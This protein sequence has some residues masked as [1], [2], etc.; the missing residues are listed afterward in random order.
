MDFSPLYLSAKGEVK[1]EVV[2]AGYGISAPERGYDDY[3]G[4]DVK[5]KV[6][7]VLR[8]APAYQNKKSPFSPQGAQQRWASFQAK[9]DLAADVETI[10][11]FYADKRGKYPEW[12]TPARF[13]GVG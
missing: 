5:G 9:A 1:G 12:E 4:L 8:R 10:R 6:V 11:L 13:K 3:A 2:F 7:V